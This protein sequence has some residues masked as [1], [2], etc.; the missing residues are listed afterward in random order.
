MK[1]ADLAKMGAA[2]V[3]CMVDCEGKP[4]AIEKEPVSTVEYVNFNAIISVK[5]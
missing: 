5:K 2:R 1:E 4:C 3:K